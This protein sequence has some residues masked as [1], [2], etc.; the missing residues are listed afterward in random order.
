MNKI[1][2]NKE[3]YNHDESNTVFCDD[4]LSNAV[5][6][7]DEDDL[8]DIFLEGNRKITE[9]IQDGEAHGILTSQEKRLYNK[10]KHKW[11]RTI[12]SFMLKKIE[13]K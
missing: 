8:Y 13:K 11:F 2:P 4:C 7:M 6:N 3:C 5:L 1:C 9:A 10:F 12:N